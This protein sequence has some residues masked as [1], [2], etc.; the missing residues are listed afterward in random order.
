MPVSGT[1]FIGTRRLPTPATFRAANPATV[2]AIEPPISIAGGREAPSR[3]RR[4]DSIYH[5]A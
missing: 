1:F 4:L 3:P 5:G 2:E